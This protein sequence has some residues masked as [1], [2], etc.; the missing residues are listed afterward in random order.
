M[1][2]EK[3]TGVTRR[4]FMK[5]AGIGVAAVGM[6][7]TVP[8][9]VKPA[10]ASARDFIL[11]GRPVP[12]TGP[13]AA[14]AEPTPWLDERALAEINKDGGIFVKEY[15]KK[16][17]VKVEI[18]DTGSDPTKAGEAG[19]KLILRD[20]VDMMYVS[21]TPAT[22]SPVAAVCE[23]YSV[24]SISSMMPVEMFLHGGPFHWA[25]DASSSVKDMM[26][27]Y[28]DSW[29]QVKTNKV[30][31]LLAANDSDGASWAG[32]A[33][34]AIEPAGYKVVDLGRFPEGTQDYSTFINGWKKNN[35]EILF[36]N[37]SPPAFTTAWR[38]CY[39]QGF[40]PKICAVGRAVLFP[41]VVA[42]L[43]SDIGA[44]VSTEVL[45]HPAYPFKSSL[46]GYTGRTLADD[47]E[48]ATGKQWTQ[49]I[50]GF[51]SGYEIL[52]DA[53]R[54]AESVDKETIR[55][56]LA[57]TNLETIAGPITFNDQNVAVTP[58]GLVQWL[59]GDKYPFECTIVSGGNYDSI[60]PQAKL[61]PIDELQK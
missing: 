46:A 56:A 57:D 48:K 38:Q 12:K 27:A 5:K 28:I 16:V 26:A 34:H 35:V 44:G 8:K 20:K 54:R 36:A 30:V 19:S 1:K 17:P 32:G 50:G 24:P 37:L 39:Q 31:G 10:R 59:K 33:Q 25:F 3:N 58:V 4:D 11:V 9:L 14:F 6:A 23:R 2:K 43:G 13:I 51:Y 22:V 18:V 52:A 29:S 60:K 61:I 7:T 49:P 21:S 53:L 42:S 47:Y 55:K 15:G 41:S 40:I 45:W